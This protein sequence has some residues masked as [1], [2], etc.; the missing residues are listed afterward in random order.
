MEANDSLI[1]FQTRLCYVLPIHLISNPAGHLSQV[2]GWAGEGEGHYME[3][4]HYQY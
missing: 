4:K 1:R 3:G 2:S